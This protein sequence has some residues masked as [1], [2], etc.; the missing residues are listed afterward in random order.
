VVNRTISEVAQEP[1]VAVVPQLNRA[2]VTGFGPGGPSHVEAGN[3][4]G[5]HGWM[6]FASRRILAALLACAA[7][8]CAAWPSGGS[9]AGWTLGPSREAEAYGDFLA[10]RYAGMIGDPAA[11]ASFYRR[12]FEREPDDASRLEPAIFAT[13]IA[14]E[15]E[16]AVEVATSASKSVASASPS[17]Q[18]VLVMNDVLRGRREAALARLKTARLGAIHADL[19]TFLSAWLTW[20]DEPDAALAWL[21][22]PDGRRMLVGEQHYLKA[23]ILLAAN[24]DREAEAAFET[25]SR[26]QVDSP[27]FF[28]AERAR[29]YA[30][31]GETVRARDE[32]DA[33]VQASAATAET[34][35]VLNMQQ[36]AALAMWLSSS[37][38]LARASPELATLRNSLA[39]YADAGFA[40]ARLQLADALE[41]QERY[42]MAADVLADIAAVSPWYA[43]AKLHQARVLEKLDRPAEALAAAEEATKASRRRDVLLGA[44]DVAREQKRYAEAGA[45]Y[46][47][48]VLADAARGREDWRAL[49]ARATVRERLGDW[50]GA[51]TDLVRA[52]ELQPSSAE[53]Q[54][55]LGYNWVKRGEQVEEGMALIRQ[56]VAA[57]P[58]RGYII[59]SLGWAYFQLGEYEKA[60]E[61]L[62]RAVELTPDDGEILR[63]LGDTYWRLGRELEATFEWRRALALDPDEEETEG[64]KARLLRG[65][66]TGAPGALAAAPQGRP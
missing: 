56:A 66:P 55:F 1:G 2:H 28:V 22:V 40:P 21:N 41:D 13:L 5:L 4:S 50:P 61:M 47:E 14:G 37:G 16:T 23:F 7:S 34:D 35:A 39:L 9:A 42:E 10:A 12:A 43:D 48:V 58:D 36:G 45:L 38:A 24:R 52:L 33:F 19:L 46:D 29:L 53:L 6:G 26:Y 32:I 3:S 8:G 51:E 20:P 54:N 59:D 30:S 15:A 49:Y 11:A 57:W 17:A 25:A 44:G 64:V 60:A 62:E 31:L 63:H 27:A 18:L 65:L